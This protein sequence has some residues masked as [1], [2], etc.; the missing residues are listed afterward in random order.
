M[1]TKTQNFFSTFLLGAIVATAWPVLVTVTN[2]KVAEAEQACPANIPTSS[3]IIRNGGP[4]GAV[5]GTYT[6]DGSGYD[7]N[8]NPIGVP[9]TIATLTVPDGTV[10]YYQSQTNGVD[11]VN[12]S[13]GSIHN[14]SG[15]GVTVIAP[16]EK[17]GY[18]PSGYY[19][20]RL[21]SMTGQTNPLSNGVTLGVSGQNSCWGGSEDGTTQIVIQVLVDDGPGGGITIT[22]QATSDLAIV[23]NPSVSLLVNGGPSATVPTGGTATFS[24]ATDS[25]NMGNSCVASNNNSDSSWSGPKIGQAPFTP[26]NPAPPSGGSQSVGP[27][28]TQGVYNYSIICFGLNNVQS[29]PASVQVTVGDAASYTCAATPGTQ[30]VIRGSNASASISV[31]PQNGYNSPITFSL[32]SITPSTNAPQ[33]TVDSTPQTAPYSTSTP[34]VF[35]T[36][37]STGTGLYTITFVGT[38]GVI[39][40]SI[41]LNV[42]DATPSAEIRCDGQL[43]ECTKALNSTAQISW[44]SD[45]VF[46]CE[47]SNQPPIVLWTGLNGSEKTAPLT[48]PETYTLYCSGP[49]GTATDSVNINVTGVLNPPTAVQSFNDICDQVR[50]TWGPP[51]TGSPSAYKVYRR[52]DGDNGSG[53][54]LHTTANAN[55][56][57]EYTD[58]DGIAGTFYQY[59]VSA[60]YGSAE[61]TTEWAFPV[62]YLRCVPSFNGSYKKIVGAGNSVPSFSRCAGPG[63]FTLPAGQI[64]Q[65]GD[66][67]YFEVCVRS[68]GT[69]A[70]NS[71]TVTEI[72]SQDRNIENIEYITRGRNCASGSGSGPYSIG[73]MN[74][75]AA[76]S[77]LVRA[78]IAN[79]GG[80]TSSLHYFA[81]F[82]RLDSTQITNFFVN[83]LPEPFV[84]GSDI[85]TREEIPR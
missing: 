16:S 1:K 14:F 40:P 85:P 50:V 69:L 31:T 35:S 10:L 23:K 29:V 51:V 34:A 36:S 4:T 67:V 84:I 7:E 62:E 64:F 73:T 77:I 20:S 11:S 33:V 42:T 57:L 56:P 38:G 21:P 22:R 82:A 74:P 58:T 78:R 37:S 12:R 52:V 81:N 59:G 53:V 17:A 79:P 46:D 60:M 3:I 27:F 9:P 25:V 15:A 5:L 72:L 54:L 32:Q 83:T 41:I 19:F 47:V 70:L 48:S 63:S 75:G 6:N 76:C 24:W 18:Y 66:I 44:S 26:P 71:V 28:P 65:S 8:G 2:P 49:Y 80:P 45:N 30:S 68:T 55:P 39:C 13:P 61:S 43:N